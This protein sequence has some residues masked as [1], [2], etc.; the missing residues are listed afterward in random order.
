MNQW[1]Q[2]LNLIAPLSENLRSYLESNLQSCTRQCFNEMTDRRVE[3]KT[4]GNTFLVAVKKR[5]ENDRYR[6]LLPFVSVNIVYTDHN[7]S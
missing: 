4:D 7:D 5:F 6:R 1:L 3:R 2:L